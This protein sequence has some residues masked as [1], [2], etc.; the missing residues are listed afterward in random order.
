MRP[1]RPNRRQFVTAAGALTFAASE[2]V[3]ANAAT[4]G[5][6]QPAPTTRIRKDVRDL[7][8]QEVQKYREAFR[9]LIERHARPDPL[10]D[11]RGMRMVPSNSYTYQGLLHTNYCPHGNWWFLP[12]HRAYLFYMEE[13]LR[14]AVSDFLP[15]VELTI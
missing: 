2:V 14:E 7:S 9:R 4:L 11:K 1:I 8:D 10:P 15:Q 12:W 6:L 5:L 13:L 3:A